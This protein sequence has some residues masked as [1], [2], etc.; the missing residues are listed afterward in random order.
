MT[1]HSKHDV[2][3]CTKFHGN[4]ANN[5]WSVSW[6]KKETK[7]TALYQPNN[8]AG[9]KGKKRGKKL[10]SPKSL[11]FILCAPNLSKIHPFALKLI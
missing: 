5:F 10:K 11:G 8:G 3:I 4:P 7:K 1:I 9:G 6:G 2:N